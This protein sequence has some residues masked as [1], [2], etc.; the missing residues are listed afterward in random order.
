M[1]NKRNRDQNKSKGPWGMHEYDFLYR[2]KGD[3]VTRNRFISAPTEKAATEQFN[4]IMKKDGVEV[5]I[6]EI[7]KKDV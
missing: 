2:K 7:K 6:L 5:E 1:L 4:F 3:S